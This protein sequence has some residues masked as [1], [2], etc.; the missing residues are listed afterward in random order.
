MVDPILGGEKSYPVTGSM[1]QQ[2]A[3]EV[4]T[5][6]VPTALLF[7]PFLVTELSKQYGTSAK[8]MC[9]K[10]EHCRTPSDLL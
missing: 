9:R 5:V 1:M 7:S 6:A 3:A 4:T 8:F 10:H 2:T